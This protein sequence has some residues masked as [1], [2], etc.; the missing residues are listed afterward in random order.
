MDDPSFNHIAGMFDACSRG[1]VMYHARF[2][3][4]LL[5]KT[6]Q[7]CGEKEVKEKEQVNMCLGFGFTSVM[8]P[9][10]SWR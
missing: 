8:C 6:L 5:T 4:G 3:F 7:R 2:G 9:R 1:M 10:R